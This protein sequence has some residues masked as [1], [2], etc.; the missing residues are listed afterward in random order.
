MRKL[1]LSLII[2]CSTSVGAL[3]QGGST[4]GPTN[5]IACN[6]IGTANVAS[7]TTTSLANG[8]AGQAISVCGWHVTS[9]Q[10]TANTF[11]LE[12]GTQG[13]PCTTPTT[14][15]PPFVVTSTA[16]SA[17]NNAAAFYSL[18]SGAQLCVVTTGATVG[19]AIM[20]FYSQF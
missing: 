11:Q 16:P 2:L 15:T 17:N 3:A 8:V 6:K 20:V 1:A 18:P 4:V 19:T 12:Q 7:A 9:T 5:Q 14:F 13:G 10:A